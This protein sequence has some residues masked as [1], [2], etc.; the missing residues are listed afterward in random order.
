MTVAPVVVSPDIDSNRPSMSEI[1]KAS[2]S[3]SG[4]A[5]NVPNTVQNSTTIINPSLNR[6]SPRFLRRGSHNK[7]PVTSVARKAWPKLLYP[8]ASP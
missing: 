3:R 7:N 1:D 8:S 5:P 2:E 4:K 6:R